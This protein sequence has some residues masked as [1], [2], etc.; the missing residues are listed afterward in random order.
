MK[1]FKNLYKNKIIK[2]ISSNYFFCIMILLFILILI[3]GTIMQKEYGLK[4]I[5]DNYFNSL[6]IITDYFF[7][8]GGKLILILIFSSLLLKT[9]ID[10]IKKTGTFIIHIGILFFLLFSFLFLKPNE[11]KYIIIKENENSNIILN[12]N[13]Y[14]I[15]VKIH[16]KK[17]KF[18][19]N[20][21]KNINKFNDLPFDIKIKCFKNTNIKI[22]NKLDK[23]FFNFKKINYFVENEYNKISFEIELISKN[24]KLFK[25]L[26]LI[27]NLK[28][29]INIIFNKI[30]INIKLNK[31]T[32]ILPFNIYLKSFKKIN[33][34]NT[35]AA[36]SFESN[37]IIKYKN[38]E[39][40]Y[41]IK[42]NKPLR[43]KNYIFYQSSFIEDKKNSTILYVVKD[44][45]IIYIYLSC[46]I[47]LIG[48]IYHISNSKSRNVYE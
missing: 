29:D 35:S 21:L 34:T 22:N 4:S 14:E 7:F 3:A 27:E 12:N 30:E 15:T 36:K 17:I 44:S 10:G 5:Q 24:K 43:Y 40:K 19:S 23:V 38:T 31:A 47:I 45:K 9:F 32:E 48:F 20:N 11:E 37:I 39:W 25:K 41:N 13:L 6:I 28:D 42:M 26:F 46:F 16:E 18:M 1:C 8:P 2:I 33:Y